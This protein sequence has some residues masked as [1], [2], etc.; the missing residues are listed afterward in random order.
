MLPR[1]ERDLNGFPAR[2]A[3]SRAAHLSALVL[4]DS[5]KF[6]VTEQ[7]SGHAGGIGAP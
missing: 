7:H 1:R 6:V 4:R 2:R 5:P 3:V